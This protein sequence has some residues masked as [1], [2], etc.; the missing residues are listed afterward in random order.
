MA[1]IHPRV[2]G[3]KPKM[4]KKVLDS[5]EVKRSANG[6]FIARHRYDNSGPGEGYHEPEEHT[7]GDGE[8]Q[9]LLAHLSEH[10]GI[11]GKGKAKTEQMADADAGEQPDEDGAAAC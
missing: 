9:K 4:R 6:G 11:P 8:G 10:M 3:E 7:F 2:A 5:V 1:N